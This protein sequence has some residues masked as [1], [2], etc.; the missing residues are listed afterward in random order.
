MTAPRNLLHRQERKGISMTSSRQIVRLW[1]ELPLF[2]RFQIVGW[3]GFVIFT[4]PIKLSLDLSPASVVGTYL[5]RDG[6]SFLLTLAMRS[7]YRNMSASHDRPSRIAGTVVIV[8]ITA[9]TTQMLLFYFFG[10]FFP[11]EEKSVFSRSVPLG[12]LYY[13]TGLFTCW[14]LLYFGIKEVRETMQKDLRLALIE[15]ESRN[16]QLLMLRAQ[17]N[18]HF[19]FNA[20]NV[21]QAEIGNPDVPVKKA[22]RELTQY[23]RFSLD[24]GDDDL[25]PMGLEYDAVMSYFEVETLRFG[26]DLIFECRIDEGARHT[27]VPGIILQPLVEN[28][29]K[30]GQLTADPPIR[31][32]VDIRLSIPQEL[33]I[34]VANTGKW[35][36]P[37][38]VDHEKQSHIGLANVRHRLELLYPGKDHLTI[39]HDKGWVTIEIVIPTLP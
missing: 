6:F 34:T 32:R 35:L 7:I 23:L 36:E 22:V 31:V 18:P 20:L 39:N 37:N 9:G 30:Y 11:F 27:L 1:Y 19:L 28:A 21:I 17:M 38:E 5:I 4:L 24:H 33:H 12:I 25:I 13:R 16:A 10:Q 26:A 29:V 8:S 14:S 15:S 2:W 3:T